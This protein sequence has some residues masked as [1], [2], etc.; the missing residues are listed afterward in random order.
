MVAT[1]KKAP[2]SR[3]LDKRA[4]ARHS[5]RFHTSPPKF[6]HNEHHHSFPLYT[7][8]VTFV[9]ICFSCLK[10]WN[11]GAPI[12]PPIILKIYILHILSLCTDYCLLY[13]SSWGFLAKHGPCATKTYLSLLKTKNYADVTQTLFT[14][15]KV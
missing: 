10:A 9:V 6:Y 2:T 11:F 8:H 3:P 5:C 12:Q 14:G 1:F 7:F 15:K 4:M 13:H